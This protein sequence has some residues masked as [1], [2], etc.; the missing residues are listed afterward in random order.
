VRPE[1]GV[2]KKEKE[3][4]KYIEKETEEDRGSE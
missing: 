2:K 3:T 4:E 1:I